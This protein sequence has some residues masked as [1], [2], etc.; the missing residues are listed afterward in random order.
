MGSLAAEVAGAPPHR[1]TRY[2]AFGIK[3]VKVGACFFSLIL[4]L[5]FPELLFG[6]EEKERAFGLNYK[7]GVLNQNQNVNFFI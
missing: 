5:D 4:R 3:K 1:G 2:L 6:W 7:N